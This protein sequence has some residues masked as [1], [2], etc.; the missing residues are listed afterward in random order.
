MGEL[1]EDD[2]LALLIGPLVRMAQGL[3]AKQRGEFFPFAA[4][5]NSDGKVEML[6]AHTG[7]QPKSSD[8][9]AFLRS[10]LESMAQQGQIRRMGI[11]AN[12]AA[13]LP[14]HDEKVD[15]ICC[16]IDRA[17]QRPID[18]YVPFHKGFFGYKYDKWV[19]LPGTLKVFPTAGVQ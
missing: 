16:F 15:A 4:F 19:A 11:C 5:I 3:L 6:G 14:G 2:E 17:G 1:K 13:R 7:E 8:M 18:L 10:A 12:V 9:I